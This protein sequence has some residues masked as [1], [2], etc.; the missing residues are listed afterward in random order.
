MDFYPPCHIPTLWGTGPSDDPEGLTN[1]LDWGGGQS[2]PRG[3]RHTHLLGRDDPRIPG[4]KE[5]WLQSSPEHPWASL[6]SLLSGILKAIFSLFEPVALPCV[7]ASFSL[8]AG[9]KQNARRA[10]LSASPLSTFSNKI[11]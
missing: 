11:H 2:F 7:G 3:A 1:W 9:V 10:S 8:G 5:Y 6:C 4:V